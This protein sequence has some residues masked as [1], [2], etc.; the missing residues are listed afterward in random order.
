MKACC[1]DSSSTECP[2]SLTLPRFILSHLVSKRPTCCSM[3]HWESYQA[4]FSMA[5]PF[6]IQK[7]V[8]S[9]LCKTRLLEHPFLMELGLYIDHLRA[10]EPVIGLESN[11][12]ASVSYKGGSR[13]KK[14]P[15]HSQK[16]SKKWMVWFLQRLLSF[17]NRRSGLYNVHALFLSMAPVSNSRN[18]RKSSHLPRLSPAPHRQHPVQ[19]GW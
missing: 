1:F 18:N 9:S 19:T 13:S 4:S 12:L 10:D 16:P 7:N 14:S 5:N 8:C 3:G 2:K 11:A 17:R 15:V 6:R